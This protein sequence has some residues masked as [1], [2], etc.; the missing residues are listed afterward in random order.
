MT[1]PKSMNTTASFPGVAGDVHEVLRRSISELLAPLDQLAAKSANLLARP[2]GHFERDGRRYEIPRYVFVGPKGGDTPIPVGIFAGIYGDEP[3]GVRALV[4]FAQWLEAE[5]ELAAG[6]CLFLYPA[7]NPTGLE[8]GTAFSSYG[9]DL[10]LELLKISA[11]PEVGLL[12][13]ELAAQPLEGIV[14]LHTNAKSSTFH[15]LVRGETFAQELL[16]PALAAAAALLPVEEAAHI[17]GFR[18]RDV[19]YDHYEGGLTNPP[20]LLPRPFEVILETPGQVPAYLREWALVVALRS[21]LI[22]YRKF[23]AYAPNL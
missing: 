2:I 13:A 3:E 11:E 15:G 10:N 8:A 7:C 9:K 5:P 12:Q 19:S 16:A 22:E 18:A 6:Y 17:E 14:K 23:M 20:K 1:E 4:R 21:L